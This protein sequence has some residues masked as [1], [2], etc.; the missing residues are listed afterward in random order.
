MALFV[1]AV[2]TGILAARCLP[3]SGKVGDHLRRQATVNSLALLAHI[4]QG[5]LWLPRPPWACWELCLWSPCFA[6]DL[7]YQ[8]LTGLPA[9]GLFP[10]WPKLAQRHVPSSSSGR[11]QDPVFPLPAEAVPRIRLGV[12]RLGLVILAMLA[13]GAMRWLP[14]ARAKS[15]H[16]DLRIGLRPGERWSCPRSMHI[17]PPPRPVRG[18]ALVMLYSMLHPGR[19]TAVG[20]LVYF[21]AGAAAAYLVWP[22][23]WAAP[24]TNLVAAV[25]WR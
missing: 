13:M 12:C 24:L 2:A 11:I 20:L 23:L 5:A 21:A 19:R 10:D 6:A 3:S 25:R 9:N 22:F 16:R 17:D 1:L 4:P 14:P 7:L 15:L 8:V 18:A